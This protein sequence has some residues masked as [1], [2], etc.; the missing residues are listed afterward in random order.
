MSTNC[1]HLLVS[2]ETNP[3]SHHT[4]FQHLIIHNSNIDN[5]IASISRHLN[6]GELIGGYIS[7]QIM[8]E[9]G[10]NLKVYVRQSKL[11]SLSIFCLT[12]I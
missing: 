8:M 5:S 7:S 10:L 3:T 4:Q 1:K 11:K 9:V 6:K 2:Q 12:K